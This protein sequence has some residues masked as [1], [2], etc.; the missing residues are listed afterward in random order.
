MSR[1]F[2]NE[3]QQVETPFVPPRAD[4]P[5]GVTNYVTPE[6]LEA[7]LKEKEDLL[8]RLKELNEGDEHGKMTA[9]KTIHIQLEM[10]ESRILTANVVENE[11]QDMSEVRFGSKVL[12]QI[13][14]S[15][16]TRT[17]QIVGVDE[18]NLREGKIAFTSPLAKEMMNKK[19]DE[20]VVLNLEH[21]QSVFRV[22]KIE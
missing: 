5:K 1:A 17:L 20:R 8:A 22:L 4:L 19:V 7:L 21:G 16:K 11:H 6:G 14:R 9:I 18:A 10:L 15:K 13:G 12:L 2:I 3:D